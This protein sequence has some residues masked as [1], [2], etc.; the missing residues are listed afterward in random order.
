MTHTIFSQ[1]NKTYMHPCIN[2]D[3]FRT[4]GMEYEIS[5]LHSGNN[6]TLSSNVY[7][8][9]TIKRNYVRKIVMNAHVL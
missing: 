3:D 4:P 8:I 6:I 2:I 5:L 9:F 7:K 1:K